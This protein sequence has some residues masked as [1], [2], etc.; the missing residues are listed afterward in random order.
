MKSIYLCF[1]ALSASFV[2]T[3]V[4]ALTVLEPGYIVETYATYTEA[5]LRRT[6][7]S[8]TFGPH[9]N[10]Y[11]SNYFT[12]TIWRITPDGEAQPFNTNLSGPVGI[13]RGH[14]PYGE[15]ILY[16]IN[17]RA[18]SY[19]T[20]A[21]LNQTGVYTL[22]LDGTAEQF[23]RTIMDPGAIAICQ[24]NTYDHAMFMSTSSNENLWKV[25]IHGELTPWGDWP[26]P[27]SGTVT[28]LAFDELGSY[29]KSLFVGGAF[30]DDDPDISGLFSLDEIGQATRFCADLAETEYIAFDQVGNFAH[31]LFTISR[32]GFPSDSK[33]WY[34]DEQGKAHL[35]A[36]TCKNLH[37]GLA[38]D[39]EGALYVAEYEND[40]MTINKITGP[41]TCQ[42]IVEEITSEVEMALSRIRL[43][44][45]GARTL[46][47][48]WGDRIIYQGLMT[49]RA[50]PRTS[51]PGVRHPLIVGT[52][53]CNEL[54]L[55]ATQTGNQAHTF[56]QLK[57]NPQSTPNS[58]IETAVVSGNS[59]A[60][61]ILPD[62]Y[63]GTFPLGKT[64][65]V[66][67]FQNLIVAVR[68]D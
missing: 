65:E 63:K 4:H 24:N 34:V 61:V 26:H 59:A 62:I 58:M 48:F 21:G 52:R 32:D 28:S 33:I 50:T 55:S 11:V 10:L 57:L 47:L 43:Q 12:G 9:G 49:P 2:N 39:E 27:A 36:T 31:Q 7:K 6:P 45:S 23:S 44:A 37:R 19:N 51:N 13:V 35:F 14:H 40:I 46:T 64:V 22:S 1:I 17:Y 30:G 25:D 29:G 66:A 5:N 67:F 56:L 16:V 42:I 68:I 54:I 3:H 53:K 18:Y 60:D 20:Q 38:F 41:Q 15:Q 8:M